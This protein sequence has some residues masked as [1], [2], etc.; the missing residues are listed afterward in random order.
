MANLTGK[1]EKTAQ[2]KKDK[3]LDG[4]RKTFS[5][6]DNN[7]LYDVKPSQIKSPFQDFPAKV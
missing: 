3:E 2:E 7:M 5:G 4:N 6:A 1:K